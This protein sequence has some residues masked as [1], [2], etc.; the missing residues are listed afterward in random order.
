MV[1]FAACL[2][3]QS[4]DAKRAGGGA[5]V[6]LATRGSGNGEG[7]QGIG[8]DLDETS[9]IVLS[10]FGGLA[11]LFCALATLGKIGASNL[12]RRSAQN[13]AQLAVEAL[14][15]PRLPEGARVTLR[16]RGQ[17]GAKK[18]NFLLSNKKEHRS[19]PTTEH[20]IEY[21]PSHSQTPTR[22]NA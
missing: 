8:G 15:L 6:A 5:G 2:L 19:I 1:A 4:V 20:C 22:R 12:S 10:C 21:S 17:G 16:H 14:E 18:K 7:N 13:A 11:V 9:I 3:V